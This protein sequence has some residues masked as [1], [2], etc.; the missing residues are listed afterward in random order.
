MSKLPRCKPGTRRNKVTKYCEYPDGRPVTPTQDVPNILSPLAAPIAA[1][2]AK[3]CPKGQKK[4]K[5]VC[6]SAATAAASQEPPIMNVPIH[7]PIAKQLKEIIQDNKTKKVMVKKTARV[8]KITPESLPSLQDIPLKSALKRSPSSSTSSKSSATLSPVRSSS[9]RRKTAKR[10]KKHVKFADENSNN[11]PLEK[12]HKFRKT[13]PPMSKVLQLS[14]ENIPASLRLDIITIKSTPRGHGGRDFEFGIGTGGVSDVTF[15]DVIQMMIH[16]PPL[17]HRLLTSAVKLSK[18]GGNNWELPK[19][20]MDNISLQ[21]RFLSALC[22]N[23]TLDGAEPTPHMRKLQS[24][25]Q[26]STKEILFIAT[27]HGGIISPNINT[28]KNFAQ[29]NGFLSEAGPTLIRAF[30]ST[31]G[32]AIMNELESGN[33][34]WISTY[35]MAK[36]FG[37]YIG[38][39]PAPGCDYY[40]ARG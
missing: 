30:W 4:I 39:E 33:D 17:W 7:D 26:G 3:R 5:G 16:N 29:I 10:P 18:N 15:Q 35:P 32:N 38:S 19:L 1:T 20:N 27:P 14:P 40:R 21:H 2:T 12:V 13:M 8:R 11:S 6:V 37:I 31:V 25:R 22:Y 24:E 36:W 23:V 28:K 34:V 9:S